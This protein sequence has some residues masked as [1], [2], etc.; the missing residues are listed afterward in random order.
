MSR[1][2]SPHLGATGPWLI[3][4]ADI[5]DGSGR[6]PVRGD[7]RVDGAGT[8]VEIAAALPPAESE[9]VVDGAGM[10]LAPGFV[11]LH[12]HS[13]LYTVLR[14]GDGA[15]IGDAPKLLQGCTAQVFGQDGMSA[16]PVH[17]GDIDDFGHYIAGLDG[18]LPRDRWTWSTFGE[19]LAELRRHSSTRAIGLVG[20]GT[21]R[22]YVMGMESRPPTADEL[23]A[24]Q[25]ALAGALDDG[26]AGLSTGLVYVP[27]AYADTAEVAALCEVAAAKG[28]PFFVHVRS[29]S[30]NVE[31]A[32]DEVIDV[33]AATGVHLH[34][35]HI[36]TAGRAN[37]PKAQSL[38]D[39]IAV[40]QGAGVAITADIH[41]YTAGS[42][43]ATVLLPP[44]LLEGGHV[45]A[46]RRLADP[47]VRQRARRQLLEDVTGWDN[48]FRFSGGWEGLTVADAVDPSLAGRSFADI[49]HRSGVADPTSQEAFDAV[50]EILARNDLAVSLISF[51]NVEENVAVFMGMPY[52]S[53]GSDG[54]V[55]PGGMPHPRLYGTFTRVLGRF[56]RE[57]GVMSLRDAIHKMTGRAAAI[58][59]A[60]DRLGSITP[61]RPADLV[62]FDPATVRDKAT[63]EQPRLVGD[64][65]ESVWVGGRMVVSGQVLSGA[66]PAAE[67]PS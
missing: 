55:N 48:W 47:A 6:D 36:K 58:V 66:V 45:A 59:G 24:M 56:V 16:A 1:A 34:Y 17:E 2:P 14:D 7:V 4:G 53:I 39:K 20:H 60:A 42:S 50:F 26:A 57:L 33:A 11:D 54:V 40:A 63:Y 30:E 23:A 38:L 62:L 10:A 8:V 43:T 46:I 9:R 31:E 52:T 13:D 12:S 35:S 5:H 28:K 37:W 67:A 51:N 61:G 49:I 32:T 22:R 44:W 65:I 29:E 25:E 3:R 19:Y 41:P 27:A 64:G 15:P 21:I 18:R